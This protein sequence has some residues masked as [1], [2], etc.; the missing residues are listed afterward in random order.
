MHDPECA[1]KSHCQALRVR[2]RFSQTFKVP[3]EHF[4]AANSKRAETGSIWHCHMQ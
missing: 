1:V 2:A 4:L 3:L